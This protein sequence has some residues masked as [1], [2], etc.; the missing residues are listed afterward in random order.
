[1]YFIDVG[2]GD[3]AI[4]VTPGRKKILIDGGLNKRALGFLAWKY[5]LDKPNNLVIDLLV[6]THADDDHIKLV[7]IGH[8]MLLRNA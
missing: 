1:M 8:E 2:T 4:V 6:L 7:N 5:R 3:S